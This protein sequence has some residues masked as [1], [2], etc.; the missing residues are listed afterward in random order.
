MQ[1]KILPDVAHDD[2]FRRPED[3]DAPYV[4]WEVQHTDEQNIHY[5]HGALHIYDAGHELQKYTWVN[6]NVPLIEQIRD[7]LK[8]NKYP[9]FVSEGTWKEKLDRIQH[10]NYLGRSYRSFAKIGG[11]LFMFGLSLAENDEHI[12]TLMDDNKVK[13]VFIGVFGKPEDDWNK[14]MIARAVKLGAKRPGSR[15]LKVH[16]YDAATAHVWN[17]PLPKKATGKKP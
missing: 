1:D 8:A 17:R 15:P 11:S 4:V 16:F 14:P 7:A 2:G 12:L 6:T 9:I 13:D 10:S 5:L 3:G